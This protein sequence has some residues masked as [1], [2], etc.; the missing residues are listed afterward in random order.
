MYREAVWRQNVPEFS[1]VIQW[2][3]ANGT[4]THCKGG[5]KKEE[6]KIQLLYIIYNLEH[7]VCVCAH[8]F[9]V[10]ERNVQNLNK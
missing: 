1:T 8:I 9:K 4:T 7:K 6:E 10:S 2:Q 3:F 5:S